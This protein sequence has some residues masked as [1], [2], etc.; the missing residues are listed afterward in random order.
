MTRTTE[1]PAGMHQLTLPSGITVLEYAAPG[2]VR[3]RLDGEPTAKAFPAKR[4]PHLITL[5]P[6]ASGSAIA[7]GASAGDLI[8]TPEELRAMC[9]GMLQ[10]LDAWDAHAGTTAPGRSEDG[11][12]DGTELLEAATALVDALG[13]EPGRVAELAERIDRAHVQWTIEDQREHRGERLTPEARWQSCTLRVSAGPI[14]LELQELPEDVAGVTREQIEAN[15]PRVF[16][17]RAA[18]GELAAAERNEDY[19]SWQEVHARLDALAAAALLMRQELQHSVPWEEAMDRHRG[20]RL[21]AKGV[22]EPESREPV[23]DAAEMQAKAQRAFAVLLD[24]PG[25]K[26]E[27]IEQV[28]GVLAPA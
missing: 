26:R 15:A 1:L 20:A 13:V 22:E 14:V 7:T 6:T 2:G 27:K 23:A 18:G 8:G 17:L 24:G 3:L 4:L 19:R 16:D 10:L 25:S 12:A 21:L 11:A 5:N 28:L 9:S